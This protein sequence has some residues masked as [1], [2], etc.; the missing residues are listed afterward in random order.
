MAIVILRRMKL[1]TSWVVSLFI[2]PEMTFIAGAK[3]NSDIVAQN[4][5]YLHSERSKKAMEPFFDEMKNKY[6]ELHEFWL[7]TV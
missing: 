1:E 4:G 2:R 6:P 7:N 3:S 5:W